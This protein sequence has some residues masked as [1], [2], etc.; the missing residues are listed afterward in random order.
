[1][2]HTVDLY[3]TAGEFKDWTLLKKQFFVGRLCREMSSRV[4]QGLTMSAR[5]TSYSSRAAE[6]DR[7]KTITSYSFC[8]N[9]IMDW[10]LTGVA[11]GKLAH[12][13]GV[14]FVLEAGHQNNDE[15]TDVFH[16]I[17][18]LHDL[19]NVLRSIRFAEKESSR[20]IQ[21]AD[22]IAFYSRRHGAAL[23]KAPIGEEP[24]LHFDNMMN[25]VAGS[26]PVRSF[27]ATDFDQTPDQ[28]PSW[29]PPRR[30]AAS[31]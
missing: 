9:V 26:I 20:A 23:E 29:R 28:L 24:Q 25:L 21:M 2:L 5:K 15:A 19:E 11:T 6:S 3:H 16:D 12:G 8:F 4:L 14:A 18:K 10:I 13:E 30:S 22:L 27:V 31:S 17:R 7:K 1:V